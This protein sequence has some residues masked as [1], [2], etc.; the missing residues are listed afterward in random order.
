MPNLDCYLFSPIH[1]QDK[2]DFLI[3]PIIYSKKIYIIKERKLFELLTKIGL[4]QDFH[5]TI[6]ERGYEYTSKWL[7]SKELLNEGV[8]ENVSQYWINDVDVRKITDYSVFQKDLNN[9]PCI[10]KQCI[11]NIFKKALLYNYIQERKNEFNDFVSKELNSIEQELLCIKNVATYNARQALHKKN[12]F[13]YLLE[14]FLINIDKNL[15]E[16]L[17][18]LESIDLTLDTPVELENLALYRVGNLSSYKNSKFQITDITQQ[19]CLKENT[20]IRMNIIFNKYVA[21]KCIDFQYLDYILNQVRILVSDKLSFDKNYISGLLADEND[22]SLINTL[23]VVNDCIKN[24]EI[25]DND[26]LNKSGIN[27]ITILENSRKGIFKETNIVNNYNSIISDANFLICSNSELNRLISILNM[28]KSNI[29]K[30]NELLCGK[31]NKIECDLVKVSL[32][33]GNIP[34]YPVGFAKVK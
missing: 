16:D 9:N 15:S 17:Q 4:F 14:S 30:F 23:N 31:N 8:L 34:H 2:I 5:Q 12:I 29:N 33:K 24:I 22:L 18:S 13:K 28:E 19:E 3:P 26:Q 6:R 25:E 27:N 10:S 21:G 1:I 32:E 7:N 20:V 11:K